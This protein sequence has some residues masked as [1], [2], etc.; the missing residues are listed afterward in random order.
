M[1]WRLPLLGA[2]SAIGVISPAILLGNGNLP[3][4]VTILLGVIFSTYLLTVAVREMRR[5]AIPSVL[6]LTV[7]LG[8]GLALAR[9]SDDVHTICRWT[10]HKSA[11]KAEVLAQPAIEGRFRHAEWDGWGFSASGETV[12]YLVFDPDDSLASAAKNGSSG[13]F[14]GMPCEVVHVRRLENYWYTVLFYTD[15]DWEHCG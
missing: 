14:D 6:M 11:Y 7:F 8:V 1:N 13:K 2:L 10:I 3:D 9:V 12:V 15:T 4:L 5:Q